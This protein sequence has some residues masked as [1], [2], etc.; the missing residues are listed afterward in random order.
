LT[1]QN[2]ITELQSMRSLALL[3]NDKAIRLEKSL[4]VGRTASRPRKGLTDQEIAQVASRRRKSIL[5]NK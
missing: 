3:L 5:K 2:I 1:N 4:G